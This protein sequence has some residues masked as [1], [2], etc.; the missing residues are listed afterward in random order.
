S[1]QVAGLAMGLGLDRLLMLRKEIE[2]IRLLRADDPRIARQMRDL[3]PYVPVSR[4][5]PIR[6]DLSVAVDSALTA[7]DLGDRIREALPASLHQLESVEVL[8]AATYEELPPTVRARLGMCEGQKNVVVRLVLRDPARTLT[9][10]EANAVCDLVY[11]AIHQGA[12][13]EV[14]PAQP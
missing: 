12:S 1:A 10:A 11:R 3:A 6:R 7:E 4:Q 9:G 8:S 2:D 13:M 14:M 5:P